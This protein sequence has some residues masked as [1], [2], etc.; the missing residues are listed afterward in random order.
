MLISLSEVLD[1]SVHILL[2][3]KVSESQ[4][5]DLKA[6]SEKLEVINLQLAHRKVTRK[7]ILR[8]I[9]ISLCLIIITIFVILL[10]LESPYLKWDYNDPEAAVLG[11]TFHSLEWLFTRTAPILFIVSAIGI[12]LTR[13]K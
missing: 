6:I 9:F 3:E 10:A 1:T 12:F 4:A 5:E 11:V 2:G 8:W 13:E 7:K